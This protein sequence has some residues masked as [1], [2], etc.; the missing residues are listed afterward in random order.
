MDADNDN[1]QWRSLLRVSTTGTL[2]RD[3][4][5]RLKGKAATTKMRVPV[6]GDQVAEFAPKSNTNIFQ[7]LCPGLVRST[8]LEKK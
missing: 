8:N 1:R 6:K 2:S 4:K 5:T 7:M 3:G